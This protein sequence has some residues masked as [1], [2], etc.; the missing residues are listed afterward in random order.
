[1]LLALRI[2]EQQ[3]MILLAVGMSACYLPEKPM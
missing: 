2:T 1:M 3:Q